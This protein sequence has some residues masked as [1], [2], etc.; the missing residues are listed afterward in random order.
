MQ[1]RLTSTWARLPSWVGRG[2]ACTTC[3]VLSPHQGAST[4]PGVWHEWP[5]M[6][7]PTTLRG[8]AIPTP[9]GQKPGFAETLDQTDYIKIPTCA[10]HVLFTQR[11]SLP[12]AL[13]EMGWPDSQFSFPKL[14]LIWD[15]ECKKPFPSTPEE[16]ETPSTVENSFP[17]MTLL[18]VSMSGVYPAS[19]SSSRTATLLGSP[20][21]LGQQATQCVFPLPPRALPETVARK[22]LFGYNK[23]LGVWERKCFQDFRCSKEKPSQSF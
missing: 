8:A 20:L 15:A 1:V 9:T 22:I 4:S 3:L 14:M 23:A 17:C 18:T 5:P 12:T 7:L 21:A 2:E 10:W 13:W 16:Q 11:S 6:S 19:E